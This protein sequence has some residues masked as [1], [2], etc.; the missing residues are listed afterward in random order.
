MWKVQ[1]GMRKVQY[2]VWKVQYGMWKVQDKIHRVLRNSM[3][4][5]C[6]HHESAVQYY[7]RCSNISEK[8]QQKDNEDDAVQYH[9]RCST[10]SG[11]VEQDNEEDAVQD[12][13]AD[14][15]WLPVF[16]QSE[17]SAWAAELAS[18]NAPVANKDSVALSSPS[19]LHLHNPR[20]TQHAH[21]RARAPAH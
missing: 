8:V 2:G 14:L 19:T 21:T 4:G 6:Q 12:M 20:L 9:G 18:S 10:K 5:A 15:T 1:Y 17:K 7:G 3:E 16:K 13:A 11:K